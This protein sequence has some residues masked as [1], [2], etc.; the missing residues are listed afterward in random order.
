[1]PLLLGI[2]AWAGLY[3]RDPALRMLIP[4]RNT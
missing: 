4:L 3:L 2:V 1:M